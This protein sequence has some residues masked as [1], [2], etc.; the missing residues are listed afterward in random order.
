MDI[1]LEVQKIKDF[2]KENK[3]SCVSTSHSFS[4]NEFTQ[5]AKDLKKTFK[6]FRI[7]V[8]ENEVVVTIDMFRRRV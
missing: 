5:M 8:K 2:R 7:E 6:T 1:K 4:F 3:G